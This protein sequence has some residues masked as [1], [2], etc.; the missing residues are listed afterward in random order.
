M[1][2]AAHDGV[3]AEPIVAGFVTAVR[4]HADRISD[5]DVV[6]LQDQGLSDDAIFEVTVAAALGAA[7]R[8]LDAGLALLAVAPGR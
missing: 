1:R 2:R 5:A 8:C 7:Q 3:A 4:T 6:A